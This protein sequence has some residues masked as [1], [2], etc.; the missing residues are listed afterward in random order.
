M[1]RSFATFL[2]LAIP[3]SAGQQ[4]APSPGELSYTS[5]MALVADGKLQEACPHLEDAYRLG[6]RHSGLVLQLARCRF[7]LGQEDTAVEILESSV[8]KTSS[9]NLLLEAGKLLFYRVL[10]QQALAPLEKAW[11]Q[12][13]GS[14]DV[15]MYLAL[16]HYMLEQYR[17]SEN[18]LSAI[19]TDGPPSLEFCDLLGSVYARLEQPAAAKQQF[20]KAIRQFPDRA[21]GYL[22]LGL[23]YLE[24]GDDR[25]AKELFEKGAEKLQPGTKV[26]YTIRKRANCRGLELPRAS[27]AKDPVR[28]QTYGN[29]ARSL[30][31]MQQ[32]TSAL[33][34]HLLALKSDPDLSLAYGGIGLICQELGTPEQGRAFLQ[35]GIELDPRSADL[36]YYL[37]SIHQALGANDPAI[38]SYER[39]I[40]LKGPDVPPRFLVRL[41]MAQVASEK[42]AGAESSFTRALERD[43]NFAPA[44]YEMGKLLLKSGRV[45]LAE[46]S[47]EQAIRLDPFLREAYYSYGL[48]CM[49]NGKAVQG[50]AVLAS[51]QKKK[52]LHATVGQGMSTGAPFPAKPGPAILQ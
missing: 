52:A 14:Y 36:H 43:P 3:L 47:L 18:V 48:A 45:E 11:H 42:T 50:Q 13:P 46:R 27:G 12:Q 34:V 33:E 32:W 49:R 39:A 37:G 31:N 35:R 4:A 44:H 8:A 26:F 20:E 9:P 40:Q 6:L 21:D 38:A 1:C 17:P 15:G 22:N 30:E 16:A 28:G 41:G 7:A 19:R 24:Q 51:Y 2:L 25:S 10:Y 29:F 5:G 23:F